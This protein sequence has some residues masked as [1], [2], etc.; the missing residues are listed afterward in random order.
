MDLTKI[1]AIID[2]R[3]G[4]NG[5]QGPLPQVLREVQAEYDWLPKQALDRVS[6]RLD[7]PLNQIYRAAI[8]GK[9]LSVIPRN[10]ESETTCVV[11]LVS[12]YLEFLK[13][14]LCGKC[15][16]CREGMR[17]MHEIVSDISAG[18]GTT[19]DIELLHEL[20]EIVKETSACAQ[21]AIATD[22]LLTTLDEFRDKFEMHV[23]KKC[24]PIGEV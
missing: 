11:S 2:R 13:H 20:A 3:N 17:R 24:C 12:Y 15:L 7:L 6:E 5:E 14:D 19:E 23:E 1:D 10:G 18:K 9:G 21:G 4:H 22:L 8:L 16:P